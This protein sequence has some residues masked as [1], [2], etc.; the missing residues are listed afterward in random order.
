MALD[1]VSALAVDLNCHY[2]LKMKMQILNKAKVSSRT[3]RQSLGW[4]KL[5][6]NAT[7]WAGTTEISQKAKNKSHT[8]YRKMGNLPLKAT[9]AN[10]PL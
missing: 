2:L 3:G 10:K 5:D 1:R 9:A 7:H 6:E 4:Q 8:G